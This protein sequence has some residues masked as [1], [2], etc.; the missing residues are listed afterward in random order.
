MTLNELKSKYGLGDGAKYEP[1]P[2][3]KFCHGA[4]ERT[5][6]DGKVRF[7]ICLFVEHSMS[8]FVGETLGQVAKKLWGEMNTP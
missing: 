8:D 1:F 5:C 6:K 7:C 3:C 2:D 4:G